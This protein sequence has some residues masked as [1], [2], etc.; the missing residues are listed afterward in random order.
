MFSVK[1]QRNGDEVTQIMS[2]PIDC[3]ETSV[4]NYHNMLLNIPENFNLKETRA[5]W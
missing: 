3:T 2:G 4:I 1:L 5:P